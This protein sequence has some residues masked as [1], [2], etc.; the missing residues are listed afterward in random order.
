MERV[1]LASTCTLHLKQI[2]TDV[3][4]LHLCLCAIAF[5]LV[6]IWCMHFVGNKAI[7]MGDGRDAIQLTYGPGLTALS[8]VLP[9]VGL[10]L[11]F[12]VVDFFGKTK[13]WLYLS[14]IVTGLTAGLSIMGMHYIGNMA[15]RNYK[16]ENDYKHVIGAAAIAV[17]DCWFAF[18]IFFH[19]RE[20]WINYWWRRALCAVLLAG[21]VSGMHW[22]AALGTQYRLKVL[23]K[24][25]TLSLNINIIIAAVLVSRIRFLSL[26]CSTNNNHS[27]CWPSLDA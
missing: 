4:R 9:I 10:Y 21:A 12:S 5:G 22:V 24:G 15:T 3:L 20:Q 17:F 8:A 1:W 2:D 18:T 27:A 19:Q 13:R 14:L 26:Y 25:S 7:V 23:E 16:V 6:A 11:G